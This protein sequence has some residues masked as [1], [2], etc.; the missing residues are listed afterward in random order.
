MALV[1]N[2]EKA[3]MSKHTVD[4]R[5]YKTADGKVVEEGH[6]DAA[7]LFATPGQELTEEQAEQAG[8]LKK[9]QP[10]KNKQ[11]KASQNK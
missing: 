10:T 3:K 2:K 7:Y 8:L 5:L 6:K 4:K 9:S 1:I 11:R